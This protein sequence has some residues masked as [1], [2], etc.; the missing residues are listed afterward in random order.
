MLDLFFAFNKVEGRDSLHIEESTYD[1]K[2]FRWNKLTFK[3]GKKFT[4]IFNPVSVKMFDTV[5]M[6]ER[7]SA[8]LDKIK[9]NPNK[10]LFGIHPDIVKDLIM[11]INIESVSDEEIEEMKERKIEMIADA[12][13]RKEK[14]D[15]YHCTCK[16]PNKRTKVSENG[17][18]TWCVTC[19]KTI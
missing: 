12:K 2:F 3:N 6:R 7:V 17:I 4:V 18:N 10:T 19:K 14:Y 15:K 9:N 5:K 13:K 8:N 1:D 16:I 11:N